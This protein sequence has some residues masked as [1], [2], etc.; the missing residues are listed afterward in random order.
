MLS[1]VRYAV[2]YTLY[3]RSSLP[4]YSYIQW[5]I[6]T[7]VWREHYVETTIDGVY[8]PIEKSKL[9]G[10]YRPVESTLD[11]VYRPVDSTFWWSVPN[12]GKYT[13]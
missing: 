13:W 2:V 9:N 6:Y 3:N 1:Y 12:C 8:H 11:E 10:V 5:I 7:D 4:L